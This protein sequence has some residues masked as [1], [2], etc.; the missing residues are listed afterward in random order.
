MHRI[1][2]GIGVTSSWPFQVGPHQGGWMLGQRS[3]IS[4]RHAPPCRRVGGGL[5]VTLVALLSPPPSACK[6]EWGVCGSVGWGGRASGGAHRGRREAQI[7]CVGCLV[8]SGR[9]PSLALARPRLENCVQRELRTQSST[10]HLQGS[11]YHTGCDKSAL[12]NP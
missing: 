1:V 10:R 8:A 6:L 4:L 11:Q 9:V 2:A 12:T 3:G 7:G 5:G